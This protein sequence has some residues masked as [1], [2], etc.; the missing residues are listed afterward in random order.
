MDTTSMVS[1]NTTDFVSLA[2]ETIRSGQSTCVMCF[3][4]PCAVEDM[5]DAIRYMITIYP[6]LRSIIEPTLF[7]YKM[8]IL[9]DDDPRV[10]I[11]FKNV[12]HV[13][14]NVTYDSQ[15]YRDMIREI[16]NEPFSLEQTIPIKVYYFPDDPK[17][18]FLA[19]I[20]HMVCDGSSGVHFV[21][22]LMACLNGLKPPQL[23]VDD[24]N[25]Y[26]V[27]LEKPYSNVPLQFLRSVLLTRKDI[28]AAKDDIIIPST[29]RPASFFGPVDVY[30]YTLAHDFSVVK[31]KAKV[32]GVSLN[33]LL[34]TALAVSL[35]KGPGKNKGNTV[36]VPIAMDLRTYF[37]DQKPVFGNYLRIF[38]VRLHRKNWTDYRRALAEIDSQMNEFKSRI[39]KKQLLVPVLIE[40]MYKMIGRKN[41]AWAARYLKQRKALFTN[42]CVFST[43]GNWDM[44]NSFGTKVQACEAIGNSASQPFMVLWNTL[45]GKIHTIRHSRKPNILRKM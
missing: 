39:E 24:P 27:I 5:R 15:Q 45:H 12:F 11:L 38:M 34:I 29:D 16:H 41:I 17:P 33:T 13:R 30:Q 1:L 31:A 20:H 3:Q 25:I 44:I 10:A 7:S 22:S 40:N 19:R 6:K 18:M 42:T 28:Q 23:P 36:G 21:H 32:L 9:A 14:R 26:P 37:K 2:M 43:L 4:A 8:R 35:T